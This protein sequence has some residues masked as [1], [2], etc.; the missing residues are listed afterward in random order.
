MGSIPMHFCHCPCAAREL[1]AAHGPRTKSYLAAQPYPRFEAAPGR[2]GQFVKIFSDPGGD[3]V[4]FLREA[5]ASGYTVVLCFIGIDG[6]EMS[7][8]RVAMRV[9]AARSASSRTSSSTTTSGRNVEASGMTRRS[10][11]RSLRQ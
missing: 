7:D 9:F 3:K 4:E 11:G 8:E 5:S 10:W 2:P 1:T 6:P